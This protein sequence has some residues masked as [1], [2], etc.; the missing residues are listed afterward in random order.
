ML[1]SCEYAGVEQVFHLIGMV[2]RGFDQ[3]PG[4]FQ[5]RKEHSLH[6]DMRQI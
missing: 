4:Q 5:I 3:L 2:L 6:Q 1:C